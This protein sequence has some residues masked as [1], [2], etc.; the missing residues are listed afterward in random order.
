M[1]KKILLVDDSFF[2]RRMVSNIIDLD[3][4]LEV[5][6]IAKNGKEAVELNLRLKPDVIL[7]DVEMPIMDGIEALKMIMKER[8]CAVVMFSTLTEKGAKTTIK[9]LDEGA[10]DFIPKPQGADSKLSQDVIDRI[11]SKLKLAK[12]VPV[13]GTSG[14]FT[15]DDLKSEVGAGSNV[16]KRIV[17]IGTSTGGPKALQEVLAEIDGGLK[18]PIVIVQHMPKL[19]TKPFAERL[20]ASCNLFVKEAE[21]GDVLKTGHVYVAPGDEHIK[22]VKVGGVYKI[23]TDNG[24]KVSGHRPSVNVMYDS[25]VEL[26]GI[27]ITAVQMTGMGRDGADAMK[28]LHDKG[29]TCIVQ[30]KES[31]VVYGMPRSAVELGAADVVVS[32]SNIADE[33][34]RSMEV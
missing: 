30:D 34:L 16:F 3:K 19:F 23:K 15:R 5:V 2:M 12:Y 17:A 1:K 32:L 11:L 25:L 31:S 6:G 10:C 20:N 24:D 8:P 33:I 26:S 4:D 29:A 14:G 13:T 27:D 21:D 18:A 22:V 9:A 28:R 7:L